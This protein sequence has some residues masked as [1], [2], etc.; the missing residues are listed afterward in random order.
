VGPATSDVQIVNGQLRSVIMESQGDAVWMLASGGNAGIRLGTSLTRELSRQFWHDGADSLLDPIFQQGLSEVRSKISPIA[1]QSEPAR[2]NPF[3][4][5]SACLTYFRETF[6]HI[7]FLVA[8]HLNSQNKFS[9]TQRWYHYI[10]DPT[11]EQGDP[12]RYREFR[13]PAIGTTSLRQL[14]TNDKAL[15][16]YRKNPFSPHAIA[17]TRMTAYQKAIVMKYVDNL[18]DW[19]RCSTSSRWSRSTRRPCC[20]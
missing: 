16:A 1:G 18:L 3:H 19:T 9:D 17:R 8:N 10:F 20:T 11:A 4:P 2:Q 5:D 7:P 12:W 13:E 6:F 14:L 15:A